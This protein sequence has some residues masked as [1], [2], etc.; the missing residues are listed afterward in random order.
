MR[1]QP[2]AW[3]L[4]GM[5]A[6]FWRSLSVAVLV[7]GCSAPVSAEDW[8]ATVRATYEVSF[9]GFAVGTFEFQSEAEQRS[10]TAVGNAKLS[11]LLGAFTWDGETRSFGLLA[12]QA[13]PKPAAFTFDF[14]SSLRAGSTKVGFAD[15]AVTNVTNL[16]PPVARPDTVP[17]RE[18]HLK[19]VLDPL[20]AIIAIARGSSSNPCERRVPVFDGRE[21]FDLVLSYKGEMKVTEQQPS[22]QPGIA[23][24]CRVRYLPIA[25]HKVDAETKFMASNDAIELALRPIPSANLYVPYQVTIP[26]MAGWASIA[27]KRVDIVASPGKPQIA[28]TH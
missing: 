26:T 27:S 6:L 4:R 7:L 13:Q 25:G 3:G 9:N 17:L 12:S 20:S 14:K 24:V 18:Q 11:I 1:M 5:S 19:G 23:L 8:P 15:G 2:A 21:R 16:P 10:Y 22:G 28:L